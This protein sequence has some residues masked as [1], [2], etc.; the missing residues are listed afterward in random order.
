V[1]DI[2]NE[3]GEATVTIA[4]P[5]G[6]KGISGTGSV[7]MLSFT[8]I[9]KGTATVTLP[10]FNLKDSQLQPVAVTTAGLPVKVN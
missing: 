9:G 4:R 2:R 1:K 10:D 7:L 5:P 6:T 8:A 3:L